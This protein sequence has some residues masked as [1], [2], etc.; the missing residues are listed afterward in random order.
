MRRLDSLEAEPLEKHGEPLIIAE[1]RIDLTD[2]MP[3]TA[4]CFC[5]QPL[6]TSRFTAGRIIRA[7][8]LD[9]VQ[10]QKLL[11]TT[12]GVPEVSG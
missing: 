10:E 7:V 6:D 1:L 3:S 8:R 5:D 12:F 2:E 11:G 9:S 4:F